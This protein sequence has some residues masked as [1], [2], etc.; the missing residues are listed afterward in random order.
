MMIA[1]ILFTCSCIAKIILLFGIIGFILT[2]IQ[3]KSAKAAYQYLKKTISIEEQDT[4]IGRTAMIAL[5]VVFI[6]GLT[7]SVS[8]IAIN[9]KSYAEKK[10]ESDVYL[11]A[12]CGEHTPEYDLVS[13]KDFDLC[14]NCANAISEY[15]ECRK[16]KEIYQ[17]DYSENTT[18]YCSKCSKEYAATCC[19]CGDFLDKFNL[20]KFP[21]DN[22]LNFYFCAK[23]MQ[24]YCDQIGFD[25]NMF[26]TVAI[27]QP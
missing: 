16:C 23:C 6:V 26:E 12:A 14:K 5:R 24:K 10:S 3:S 9:T 15:I 27:T 8:E 20:A 22:G 18:T 13:G 17:L 2:A 11:C 25:P 7:F 21:D 19:G 1:A 4:A